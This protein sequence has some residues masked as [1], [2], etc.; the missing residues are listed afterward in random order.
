M[1]Q[2]PPPKEKQATLRISSKWL[3][4]TFDSI[5]KMHVDN[6]QY[7]FP[8]YYGGP[9]TDLIRELT[10][11]C[12]SAFEDCC[13]EKTT[14]ASVRIT[15]ADWDKIDEVC[16]PFLPKREEMDRMNALAKKWE[17]RRN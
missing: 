15:Y 13:K 3:L 2:Q 1:S 7:L 10:Q 4:N 9:C 11:S 6:Q 17:N 16:T 5:Q 8:G 12:G 14:E